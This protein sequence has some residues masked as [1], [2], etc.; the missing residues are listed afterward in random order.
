MINAKVGTLLTKVTLKRKTK[1]LDFLLIYNALQKETQRDG[2]TYGA[3]INV[4]HDAL[5]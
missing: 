3:F 4:I 1:P 5:S 2:R